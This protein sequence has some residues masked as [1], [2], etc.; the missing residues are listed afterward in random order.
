VAV[1]S[2]PNIPQLE[3][4]VVDTSAQFATDKK[5]KERDELINWVRVETANLEL[6][7]CSREIKL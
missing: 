5:Y 2:L 6:S 4:Y 1:P 3:V 7:L